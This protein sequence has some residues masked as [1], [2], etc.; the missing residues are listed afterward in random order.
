MEAYLLAHQSQELRLWQTR[1]AFYPAHVK[2]EQ[3]PG[4]EVEDVT[5]VSFKKLMRIV[6]PKY[7]ISVHTVHNVYPKMKPH[8]FDQ[9]MIDMSV[10]AWKRG[11]EELPPNSAKA[12]V[13][14]L[15]S[16]EKLEPYFDH[17]LTLFSCDEDKL[18]KR[19]YEVGLG[20][21]LRQFLLEFSEEVAYFKMMNPYATTRCLSLLPVLKHK[22]RYNEYVDYWMVAVTNGIQRTKP[23]NQEGITPEKLFIAKMLCV[24]T[25]ARN[26]QWAECWA[27]SLS[28]LDH[29]PPNEEVQRQFLSDLFCFIGNA[30]ARSFLGTKPTLKALEYAQDFTFNIEHPW[31]RLLVFQDAL[32][33]WGFFNL[34]EQVFRKALCVI[35]MKTDYYFTLV[36]QHLTAVMHQCEN[37]L[38]YHFS[39]QRFHSSC[40]PAECNKSYRVEFSLIRVEELIN[41][42][43]FWSRALEEPGIKDYYSA[44]VQLYTAIKVKQDTKDYQRGK[45][46]LDQ[47]KLFLRSTIGKL[48]SIE[49]ARDAKQM[50][51]YLD[52]N[53]LVLDEVIGAFGT[54]THMEYNSGGMDS[55]IRIYLVALYFHV[56]W[57]VPPINSIQKVVLEYHKKMSHNTGYRRE[58]LVASC[59]KENY[60]HKNQTLV[61]DFP[62]SQFCLEKEFFEDTSALTYWIQEMKMLDL[63]VYYDNEQPPK[64]NKTAATADA[65]ASNL[66]SEEIKSFMTNI[67]KRKRK[68][69]PVPPGES[70]EEKKRKVEEEKN[71]HAIQMMIEGNNG[72]VV[73]PTSK[74]FIDMGEVLTRNLYSFG[75]GLAEKHI[76]MPTAARP[77]QPSN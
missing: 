51:S 62:A 52:H 48:K 61:D 64:S 28:A 26:S 34:E 40:D 65:S 70:V 23:F 68:A 71:E 24:A 67:R 10:E 53:L 8:E 41:T 36:K 49:Q 1:R 19:M 7:A 12:F 69:S 77:P 39:R 11:I 27:H 54:A 45:D 18:A 6:D 25:T 35:P 72:S 14:M 38:L 9:I 15:M 20:R 31:K 2:V 74:M 47:A 5:Q 3:D 30:S 37:I 42:L 56:L 63:F 60:C 58:L 66:P 75:Y 17:L 50:K 32:I 73:L 22:N 16:C 46:H 4:N 29:V 55:L 76:M 43:D 57:N 13:L 33:V 44:Y 21:R 59:E